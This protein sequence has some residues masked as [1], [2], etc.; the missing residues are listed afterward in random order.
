VNNS[1]IRHYAGLDISITSTGYC[2][3]GEDRQIEA[4]GVIESAPGNSDVVRF[5][6][7]GTEVVDVLGLYS[8]V[9][10]A[11]ESYAYSI[12]GKGNFSRIAELGGVVKN[13]IFRKLFLSPPDTMVFVSPSTLKKYATGKGNTPKNLLNKHIYKKWDFDTDFDD[14]ADAYVLARMCVDFFD[15]RLDSDF[16]CE[17]KYEDDCMDAIAK[18]NNIKIGG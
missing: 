6:R 17:F 7:I 10:I 2:I 9:G 11:I 4:N 5:D 16:S 15:T 13:K 18:Q 14:I 3:I 1:K 8:V 12:R